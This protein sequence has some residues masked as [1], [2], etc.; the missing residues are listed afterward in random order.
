MGACT[1]KY[2]SNKKKENE[3]H[4]INQSFFDPKI[5]AAKII[6]K[7]YRKYKRIAKPKILCK[8]RD[9]EKFLWQINEI[10]SENQLVEVL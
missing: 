3:I 8:V 4:L 7:H 1:C 2:Y 10:K 5:N 6:L 9:F